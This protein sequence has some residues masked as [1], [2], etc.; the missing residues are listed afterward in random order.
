[1]IR[2]WTSGRVLGAGAAVVVAIGAGFLVPQSASAATTC[3][4]P[5]GA[6]VEL[7]QIEGGDA[8]GAST[9]GTAGA[10]SYGDRGVGFADARADAR[11]GAAGFAGGVGA[12]E[13]TSGRLLAVGVGAQALALGVLDGPGTALVVA[14]PESQAFIGDIDDPVL[15]EGAAAAA[16]DLEAIRGCVV[17]GDFRY[18]T[19]GAQTPPADL[20]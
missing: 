15:C 4:A 17:F 16:V 11:V 9:D 12:G 7:V 13:S 1:M 20:P 5:P 19:P 18:V 2:S 14:G 3:T 6:P 10:W 8:C